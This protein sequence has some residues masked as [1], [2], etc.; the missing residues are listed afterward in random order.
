MTA[1]EDDQDLVTIRIPRRAAALYAAEL[2]VEASPWVIKVGLYGRTVA[3]LLAIVIAAVLF[4][5][6]LYQVSVANQEYATFFGVAAVICAAIGS[7]L[8]LYGR[9]QIEAARYRGLI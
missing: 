4:V 8:F 7:F 5:A 9:G 6:S 2:D 3:G 1:H